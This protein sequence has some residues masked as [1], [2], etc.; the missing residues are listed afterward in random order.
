MMYAVVESGGKQY[1]VRSGEVVSFEKLSAEVGSDVKLEKVLLIQGDQS[2]TLGTPSIPG[3]SVMGEVV[4]QGR[5]RKLVVF[6]KKRRK[7]YRRT[8][9]HRQAYTQ[10][11]IKEIQPG[12]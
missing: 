9:G 11:R 6:K 10:V 7:N 4:A 2:M 8:Q 5:G 12:S 1:K 3:A